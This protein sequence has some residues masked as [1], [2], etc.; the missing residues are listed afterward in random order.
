MPIRVAC[1]LVTAYLL[2]DDRSVS[3]NPCGHAA[4]QGGAVD[5]GHYLGRGLY[6]AQHDATFRTGKCYEKP[7]II[8]DQGHLP[9]SFPKGRFA[10]LP[11]PP[12]TRA[13]RVIVG[14]MG[15]EP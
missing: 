5:A 1:P 4:F 2:T 15:F 3:A 14:A 8:A 6:P 12:S 11:A 13:E 9:S 10:G 7:H